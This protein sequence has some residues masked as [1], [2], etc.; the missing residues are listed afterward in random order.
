ME[1]AESNTAEANAALIVLLFI[2]V[3]SL[4]LDLWDTGFTDLACTPEQP[5][6]RWLP[7][8]LI[9]RLVPGAQSQ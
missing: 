6:Q 3:C 5:G 7:G 2:W 4:V 1:I 8:P 9:L